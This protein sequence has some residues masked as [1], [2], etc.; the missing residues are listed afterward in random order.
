M[1]GWKS[2]GNKDSI[3]QQTDAGLAFLKHTILK[4]T[5]LKPPV[6]REAQLA[7]PGSK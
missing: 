5:V 6:L 3:A 1:V 4:H 7:N 2:R